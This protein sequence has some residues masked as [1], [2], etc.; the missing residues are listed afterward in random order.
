MNAVLGRV[1][2]ESGPPTVLPLRHFVV[3][4]GFLL[5]GGVV[6]LLGPS[7]VR[8]GRS[9][10]AAVHLLVAGGVCLT[11]LGAMTQFVPVWSGVQLY[12]RRLTR[13]QLPLVASGLLGVAGSLL[14][15]EPTWLP[16]AGVVALLG[17]WTFVA[18]VA[19]TLRRARPWDVT[20]RHFALALVAFTLVPTFGVLLG[21]SSAR[22]GLVSV[23]Y[24]ALRATH[25]TVAVF[26]AVL[27]TVAGALAQL[28]P[29]FTQCGDHPVDRHLQRIE[30]ATLPAGVVLLAGGRLLSVSV[31]ARLGAVAVVAGVSAVALLL[32]R[33]L[34]GARVAPSPMLRRYAVGAVAL[35]L[36]AGTTPPAWL[37]DPLSSRATVGHPAVGGFLL[38]VAVGFV[39]VGTLYHV[40]PFLVWVEEYSDR[41]GLS[42][43]PAVDDLYDDRLARLDLLATGSG[44][45]LV[46]LGVPAATQAGG[47]LVLVGLVIV[48]ANL[49]GVLRAH[50]ATGLAGVVFPRW[51]RRRTRRD[52]DSRSADSEG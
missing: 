39:V 3:G 45:S 22:P 42:D 18:N 11:I 37:A 15:V 17:F 29:M 27:L 44:A 19:L 1:D 28:A 38:A 23:P 35:L 41:L 12:S 50:A 24:V 33:R 13:L 30:E 10:V 5:L 8:V 25:A 48:T 43:V 32:G 2:P 31:V 26:G 49:L 34:W 52:T 21:L 7:G 6:S 14:L 20:E 4:L 36:W 16:V 9:S 47:L 40:V 51:A 46:G